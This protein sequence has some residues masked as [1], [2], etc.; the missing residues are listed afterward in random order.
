MRYE[1]DAT[2][3]IYVARCDG[4]DEYSDASLDSLIDRL[5]SAAFHFNSVW[6]DEAI[7]I[8]NEVRIS[9]ALFAK[10]DITVRDGATLTV[11]PEASLSLPR[12]AV[13]VRG[14]TLIQEGG[15]IS[16]S[17][18]RAVSLE[19]LSSSL[20]I[21]RGGEVK[22]SGATETVR[23]EL[24]SARLSGGRVVS[25]GG[26]GV[27]CFGSLS[28]SGSLSFTSASYDVVNSSAP[29]LSWE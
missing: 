26:V 12:G 6:C 5:G 1:I 17:D 4:G 25:S 19:Y 28:L 2:D 7:T 18:S 9:G 29:H 22:S 11:L 27:S 13:R 15:S 16:A 23:I 14:G 10:S 24:G 3:G 8:K 21:M 20:Y